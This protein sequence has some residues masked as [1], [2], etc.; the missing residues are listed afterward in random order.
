VLVLGVRSA[1]CNYRDGPRRLRPIAPNLA[2]VV[3]VVCVCVCVCVC[4]VCMY[5]QRTW[6]HTLCLPPPCSTLNHT[7]Y[8]SVLP[9]LPEVSECRAW[10]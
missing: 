7:L 9:G 2:M 8:L 5:V 3:V 6:A 4:G 10:G 1:V